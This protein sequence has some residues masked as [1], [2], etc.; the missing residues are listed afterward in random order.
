MSE[1]RGCKICH[2][3]KI[4]VCTRSKRGNES[5]RNNKAKEIENKNN[6]VCKQKISKKN[7]KILLALFISGRSHFSVG[8]KVNFIGLIVL[9]NA[10][11]FGEKYRVYQKYIKKIVNKRES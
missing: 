9:C 7:K 8:F 1:K 5:A 11:V 4:K 10:T 6:N 2:C 3:S